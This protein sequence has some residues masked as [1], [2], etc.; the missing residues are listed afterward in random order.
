MLLREGVHVQEL[1]YLDGPDPALVR[2]LG[3]HLTRCKI[4]TQEAS[5]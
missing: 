4:T 3:A 1:V 5:A 2:K